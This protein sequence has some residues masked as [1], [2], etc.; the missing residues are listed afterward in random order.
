MA[1][2]YISGA[3]VL[4]REAMELVGIE[5]INTQAIYNTLMNT[6]TSVFDPITKQNL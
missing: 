5:N 4:I 3:S 1:A 2:P 6:A